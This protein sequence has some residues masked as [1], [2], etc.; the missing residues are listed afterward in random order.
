MKSRGVIIILIIC[1][2]N[3]ITLQSVAFN[4]IEEAL[5]PN[6]QSL[7]FDPEDDV[8]LHFY[9]R[10]NRKVANV[11]RHKTLNQIHASHFNASHATCIIVH[12]WQNN[13]ESK[14]NK[15]IRDS[16]LE[17]GDFNV[18]TV[19]W[20]EGANSNYIYSA[21]R[22]KKVGKFI[23]KTIDDLVE[24]K[25]INLKKLT[26]IGHSLGA[27]IA[28]NAGRNVNGFINKIVALDPAGPLFSFPLSSYRLD[29]SD[30]RYVEVIHT[31]GGLLGILEPLGDADFYPNGGMRQPGCG[32]DIAGVCSHERAH[33]YFAEALQSK[34]GFWSSKC[35]SMEKVKDDVCDS[36][37]ISSN[38][39]SL[40]QMAAEFNK[41]NKM[42]EG[43]FFLLTGRKA[44]FA[45]GKKI[46]FEKQLH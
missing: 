27:H 22:V 11:F 23:A 39:T 32:K 34:Q 44:P 28:G 6:I 16:Y 26:I 7:G 41:N 35:E 36:S 38:N 30:A 42:P 14:V 19:D 25:Y 46:Y 9:T 13:A 10:Q 24:L 18:I 2:I 21:Y 5:Q 33:I 31:N 20:G 15:N 43:L 3:P 8:S 4:R 1:N 37:S 17:I 29:A 40:F 12:G 45:L